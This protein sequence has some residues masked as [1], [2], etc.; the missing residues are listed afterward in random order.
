MLTENE[1]KLYDRQ[2]RLWGLTSQTRLKSSKILII[3]LTGLAVEITKNLMLAGVGSL[4]VCD[5]YSLLDQDLNCNFFVDSSQVGMPRLLA[6][7]SRIIDLNPRV[8]FKP[9]I[10]DWKT[11]SDNFFNNF[12]LIIATGINDL[13][14]KKLNKLT[15][16]LNKP[17]IVGGIHGLFGFC[18]LDLLNHEGTI[19][20]EKNDFRKIGKVDN[21]REIIKIDNVLGGEG[22]DKEMQRCLIKQQYKSW[23]NATSD[24]IKIQFNSEKKLIKRVNGMLLPLLALLQ[25]D[26]EIGK[27][28]ETVCI[29]PQ[30]VLEKAH[31]LLSNWELPKS[32]IVKDK[33]DLISKHAYCEY[34][35]VS[36][37][38]GGVIAQDVVNFLVKKELP[39]LNFALLDGQ[40]DQMPVYIL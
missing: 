16:K 25:L 13:E 21:Y 14:I 19:D 18:W 33:V 37:I 35:P 6:S 34:Q 11:Q 2:I 36:A 9:L 28:I 1:I 15:R 29:D 20:Y 4:T 30:L 17:L 22:G 26:S 3:N 32:M 12:D 31:R 38:L 27:P 5:I 24:A 23:Q 8:E 7:E 40:L 39:I 10:I